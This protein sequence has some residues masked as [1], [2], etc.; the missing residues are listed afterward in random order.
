VDI[1]IQDCQDRMASLLDGRAVEVN[2]QSGISSVSADPEVLGLALRQII[3]N[4]IKYS[5]AG[6]KIEIS[7]TEGDAREQ[8]L[9]QSACRPA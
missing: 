5:P 6:S 3:G 4:A 9:V 8:A 2:L 7:G 1:L